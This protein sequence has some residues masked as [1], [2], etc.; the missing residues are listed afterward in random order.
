MQNPNAR[1][2]PPLPSLKKSH[3][4]TPRAVTSDTSQ[5]EQR[6]VI[7]SVGLKRVAVA[8]PRPQPKTPRARSRVSSAP[9]IEI[10]PEIWVSLGDELVLDL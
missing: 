8:V 5:T 10:G 2:R 3:P 9:E 6:K 7:G 4:G 1:S